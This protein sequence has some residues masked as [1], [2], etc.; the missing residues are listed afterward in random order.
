MDRFFH[1]LKSRKMK[2]LIV[3]C[4]IALMIALLVSVVLNH[5][6]IFTED[7]GIVT[8]I[9]ARMINKDTIELRIKYQFPC[10]G[11]SVRVVPEDEG[12]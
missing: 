5:Y 3:L 9:S 7:L 10:G 6:N 2:W 8:G 12:E 4:S 11:Y 1:K